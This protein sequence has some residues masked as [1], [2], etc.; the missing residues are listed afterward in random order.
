MSSAPLPYGTKPKTQNSIIGGTTAS[1]FTFQ[2]DREDDP[3]LAGLGSLSGFSYATGD[4]N[5]HPRI[6]KYVLVYF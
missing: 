6:S 5:M 3:S 1:N 4:V 2:M